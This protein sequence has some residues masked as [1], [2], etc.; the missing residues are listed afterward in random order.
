MGFDADIALRSLKRGNSDI[1]KAL[2]YIRE[3]QINGVVVTSG[4]DEFPSS[5]FLP[6]TNNP[7]VRMMLYVSDQ[8][9]QSTR[10]CF[11]CLD[12]LEAESIKLRTCTKEICEYT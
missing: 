7:F 9:E 8:L 2:D 11:I 4:N 5:K 10:N 3:E 12:P 6:H 1:D